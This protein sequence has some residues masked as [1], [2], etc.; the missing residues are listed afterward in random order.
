MST[1]SSSEFVGKGH[2]DKIAD[3]V[4]DA[5]VTEAVKKNKKNQVAVE[6]LVGQKLLVVVGEFYLDHEIDIKKIAETVLKKLNYRIEEFHVLIKVNEQSPNIR[7]AVVGEKTQ[8][9]S[10]GDQG[11]VFGYACNQTTECLPLSYVLARDLIWTAQKFI[12]E[13]I[14]DWAKYDM[15]SLVVVDEETKK[16]NTIIFSIQHLE[17]IQ[18][19]TLRK[20]VLEKI[21]IP[22]LQKRGFKEDGIECLI[23]TSGAFVV[24]GLDADTGLTNRKLLVDAGGIDSRHGGGGFSGKDLSKVDRTGAYFARWICKN[25]VAANIVEWIELQIT[26]FLGGAKAHTYSFSFNDNCKYSKKQIL[27]AI[28]EIFPLTIDEIIEHFLMSDIDFENLARNGHF[29]RNDLDLPW[30]RIDKVKE[31]QQWFQKI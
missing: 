29:G 8:K 22:C 3:Q 14:W 6:V 19:N 31:I 12:D 27:Q 25:L 18:Q 17:S 20:E 11:V 2:P 30:E 4:A 7:N 5:I 23:N 21:V 26:Y 10:A 15:K 28:Q 24:G 13:K 16:I 9:I 1:F